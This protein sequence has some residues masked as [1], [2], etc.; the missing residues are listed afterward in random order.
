MKKV[1]FT[2]LGI[3]VFCGLFAQEIPQKISYQGKLLENGNPVNGTKSI[4]FTIS[5]WS[6]TKSVTVNNGLYSVTL[7]ETTPI[8]TSIFDN[9]SSVTLQISV[10]GVTLSPQTDILSVAYAYKAYKA[11][12]SV[13]AEKI[14]GNPVSGTPSTNQV[15][16]WNGTQWVPNTDLTGGPPTGT[17]S[18]DLS[19]NYPNP[20]VIGLQN[21]PV[22]SL[23]PST[24]KVL[25]WDGS[26]W[27]PQID[28]TLNGTQAGGDLSGNYPNPKVIG[29]QNRPV[30]SSTPSTNQVLTWSGNQWKPS[31]PTGSSL[32]SQSGSNIFYN[33]GNVG[34]GT[35][36]PYGIFEVFSTSNVEEYVTSGSATGSA[37]TWYSSGSV[38][39]GNSWNVGI[40][41]DLN[42]GYA[43]ESYSGGWAPRLFI[44]QAGNVGINT[45]NPQE[46]LNVAGGTIEVY[47]A[48][49]G[50]RG[51]RIR[52]ADQSENFILD[53]KNDGTMQIG[54]N[55]GTMQLS[56][57]FGV[58]SRNL[59][60][61]WRPMS[62]SSFNVRSSRSLKS[63]IKYIDQ[64]GT[65]Y[66]L[67]QIL[68]MKP[69]NYIYNWEAESTQS[70]LGFIVE[71]LPE[72]L[73]GQDGKSVNLYALTSAGIVGIKGLYL[74]LEKQ[75]ELIKSLQ[76]EIE[77]LKNKED[78]HETN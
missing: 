29:L 74:M 32:W 21:K 10:E 39:F 68:L 14:A 22:S 37:R 26:Q 4:T 62:A 24:N 7:G 25:K 59:S 8:P 50:Q 73:K 58:D 78:N 41:G 45:S 15:L 3:L 69:A 34:I 64:F 54:A 47:P 77:A 30:S 46:L 57:T 18:G 38:G 28:E 17:A 56:S 60:G 13:D 70:R 72:E 52:S 33:S 6:E 2:I 48:T 5:T 16:K 12:K 1:F 27:K 11:E 63:N 42:K 75:Q 66:W 65:A 35:S 67:E 36:N 49:D 55:S 20:K 53:M 76:E 61:T 9:T 31:N 71:E 40:R 51:I 43:I 44:T 19:G 23:A